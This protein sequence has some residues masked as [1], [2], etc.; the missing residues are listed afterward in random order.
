MPALPHTE[1]QEA[2]AW[3]ALGPDSLSRGE[4]STGTGHKRPQPP[5]KL[6]PTL[7][8]TIAIQNQTAIT[9]LSFVALNAQPLYS[10]FYFSPLELFCYQEWFSEN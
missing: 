6:A 7:M 10:A 5:Q 1:Q 2:A 3:F 4:R 8:G 9:I